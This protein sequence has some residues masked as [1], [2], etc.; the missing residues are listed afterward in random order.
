MPGWSFLY[1]SSH[2]DAGA[3][4]IGGSNADYRQP[5]CSRP[6]A[7]LSFEMTAPKV[8]AERREDVV[9]VGEHRADLFGLLALDKKI[10]PLEVY[11]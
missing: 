3:K 5:L 6:N 2:P 4:G 7:M 11:G 8:S 1:M 9:Q 10:S